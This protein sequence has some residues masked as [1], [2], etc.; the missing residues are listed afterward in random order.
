MEE[1]CGSYDAHG[2]SG[3]LFVYLESRYW[4]WDRDGSSVYLVIATSSARS[5][6]PLVR[7]H[8][9]FQVKEG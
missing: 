4:S 9:L 3:Y 1:L 2:I 5:E 7:L 8:P 6:L